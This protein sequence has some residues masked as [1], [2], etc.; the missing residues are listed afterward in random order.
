MSQLVFS[1]LYFLVE[2]TDV[3]LVSLSMSSGLRYIFLLI[4]FTYDVGWSAKVVAKTV[5][6]TLA[7]SFRIPSTANWLFCVWWYTP[8][9]SLIV[10]TANPSLMLNNL[11]SMSCPAITGRDA[12]T[13]PASVVET[14]PPQST[15]VPALKSLIVLLGASASPPLSIRSFMSD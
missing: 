5:P 10:I 7:L 2:T 11:A 14:T 15:L 4:T 9:E 13:Y 6:L 3:D 1:L 8:S 12:V